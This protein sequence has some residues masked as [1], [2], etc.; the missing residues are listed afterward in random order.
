MRLL[1]QGGVRHGRRGFRLAWAM[2]SPS[3]GA[4]SSGLM[5]SRSSGLMER[6]SSSRY[7]ISSVCIQFKGWYCLDTLLVAPVN[8]SCSEGL[9]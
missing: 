8:L 3:Q 9:L 7:V 6:M 5:E 4:R 2:S 1:L